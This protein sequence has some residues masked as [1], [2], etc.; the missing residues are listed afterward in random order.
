MSTPPTALNRPLQGPGRRPGWRFLFAHPA[1]FIALGAGSGLSR[2]APGTLATLLAWLTY[3]GW[4][5]GLDDAG[6]A[7]VLAAALLLS[8]WAGT[9]T[10]RHLALADPAPIVCDEIVSFWLILWL[11]TPA[12][13]AAQAIA[14]VLF[15]LLDGVK[16]GPIAWADQL[17]KG[18][19]GGPIGWSQGFGIL[20]DDLVAAFCTLFLIAVWRSF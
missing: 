4:A 16:P 5:S 2:F 19:R 12:S 6:R 20:F 10:A 9:V 3:A 7:G 15:R 8:W 13:F 18:R 1:H 14:F 11:L 17:F